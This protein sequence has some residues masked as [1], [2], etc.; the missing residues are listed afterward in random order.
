MVA[1]YDLKGSWKILWVICNCS[2]VIRQKWCHATHKQFRPVYSGGCVIKREKVTWFFHD[3]LAYGPCYLIVYNR[4]LKFS[5]WLWLR[6]YFTTLEIHLWLSFILNFCRTF[7][8]INLLS[9]DHKGETVEILVGNLLAF[10]RGKALFFLSWRPLMVAN[11]VDFS[12][13]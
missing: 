10:S 11:R 7:I 6:V 4:F 12:L 1:P 2:K 8:F 5:F 9:A 3:F 13:L